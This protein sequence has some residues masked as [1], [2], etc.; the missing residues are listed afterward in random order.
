MIPHLNF[1]KG[2]KLPAINTHNN[3][4]LTIGLTLVLTT[5]SIIWLYPNIVSGV[6]AAHQSQSQNTT[7]LTTGEF[8]ERE[9]VGDAV[10]RYQFS[11]LIYCIKKGRQLTFGFS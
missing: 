7:T 11:L 6:S 1:A 9:L 5:F 10:H 3:C 2:R 4:S 8:V